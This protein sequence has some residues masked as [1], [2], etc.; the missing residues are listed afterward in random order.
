MGLSPNLTMISA[1]AMHATIYHSE[2]VPLHPDIYLLEHAVTT[3]WYAANVGRASKWIPTMP[4]R[5]NLESEHSARTSC[6]TRA[7]APDGRSWSASHALFV[8]K[9]VLGHPSETSPRQFQIMSST[10]H[11]QCRSH[12]QCCRAKIIYL[13]LGVPFEKPPAFSLVGHLSYSRQ[14]NVPPPR[15]YISLFVTIG[16]KV[17]GRKRRREYG[18]DNRL[19]FECNCICQMDK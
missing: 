9:T 19:S 13:R 3:G 15:Q 6:G 11:A 16:Y 18:T 1:Q 17:S 14:D 5:A 4:I 7:R 12:T 2:R 10:G 8:F